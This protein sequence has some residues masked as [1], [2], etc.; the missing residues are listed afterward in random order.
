[1]GRVYYGQAGYE[2]CS[3]STR[4]AEAEEDGR[5]PL[6]R[7]I[8]VVAA[9]A[10]VTQKVARA[11][12]VATHDGE[13]HHTGNRARR[14]N[15]YSIDDAVRHLDPEFAAECE[16]AERLERIDA[17]RCRLIRRRDCSVFVARRST[18][19]NWRRLSERL[20]G[21]LGLLNCYGGV[22]GGDVDAKPG[23]FAALT[24]ELDAIRAKKASDEAKRV[25]R[26]EAER[27]EHE[28]RRAR[29]RAE[30]EA[31]VFVNRTHYWPNVTDEP[32]RRQYAAKYAELRETMNSSRAYD[33]AAQS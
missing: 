33:L 1:M 18:S 12:L 29:A 19:Q 15:Y 14:T 24:A 11:A 16:E 20:A 25:E 8:P 22:F 17:F 2:G 30:R 7:A 9:R 23:D 10:G 5:L 32:T 27:R 31:A 13:W 6:T 21:S 4:A 26:A 3:R 28:A